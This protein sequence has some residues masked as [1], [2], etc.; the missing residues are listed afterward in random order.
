MKL[1]VVQFSRASYYLVPPGS[2]ILL[3]ILFSNTLSLCYSLNAAVQDSRPFETNQTH[4]KYITKK[5]K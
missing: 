3:S 5:K 2:N 1:L 4:N